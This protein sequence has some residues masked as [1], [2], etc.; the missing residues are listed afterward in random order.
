MPD[1]YKPWPKD[2]EVGSAVIVKDGRFLLI[3]EKQTKVYGRWN[4]PGGRRDAGE[5]LEETAA[6]EALEEAGLK[7]NIV[8][9]LIKLEHREDDLTLNAFL[10]EITGGT[11][12]IPEDEIMG[13]GWFSPE[14][15]LVMRDSLRD[16][17]YILKAIEAY[18][19]L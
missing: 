17:E 18:S 4:F 16:A 6:R 15:I 8:M 10:A 11:L 2:V 19:S 3:Q 14:E 13:V 1:D 5:T 9:P 7:V 12:K